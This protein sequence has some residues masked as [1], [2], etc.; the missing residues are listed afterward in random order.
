MK[1]EDLFDATKVPLE[2]ILSYN[3]WNKL[4]QYLQGYDRSF[5]ICK[6]QCGK[7]L[8]SREKIEENLSTGELTVFSAGEGM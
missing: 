1:L 5:K 2:K 3:Y 4:K 8:S 6:S 7:V